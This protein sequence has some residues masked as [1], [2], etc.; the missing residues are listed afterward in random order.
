MSQSLGHLCQENEWKQQKLEIF[1]SQRDIPLSNI[2]QSITIIKL[3]LHILIL[4]LYI[5]FHLY[6][7]HLLRNGMETVYNWNDSKFN[8]QNSVENL[9]NVPKI[10]QN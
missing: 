5:K 4:N 2:V 1:L 9:L 7:Q 6:V 10:E 3:N 8:V